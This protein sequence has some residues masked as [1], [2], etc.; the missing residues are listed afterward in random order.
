MSNLKIV[1]LGHPALRAK[2]AAVTRRELKT[3]TFQKFLDRLC[4]ICDANEG[5]GI[6]APQVGVNKRIIVVHVDP[7]N[8]RY[9]DKKPFPLTVVLNPKIIKKSKAVEDGWEGDLSASL[10]AV[11]PRAKTCVVTGLDR[12]G[13]PLRLDLDYGFHARVFQHEIDHLSGVMMIDRV[14]RR[15]TICELPEWK[16]YWKDKKL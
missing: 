14:K 16:K 8:P 12:Q 6:A 1:H 3:K 10:R 11:V 4:A 5:V 7:K 2:S 9:P 13:N 15:E